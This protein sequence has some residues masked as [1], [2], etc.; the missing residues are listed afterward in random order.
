MSRVDPK[1]RNQLAFGV[2]IGCGV[3]AL[4]WR[5]KH[6][7]D[8]PSWWKKTTAG[9]EDATE[10]RAAS[11]AAGGGGGAG[12]GAGAPSSSAAPMPHLDR[13][14]ADEMR[15]AIR[16]LLAEAGVGAGW[17]T[18][19]APDAAAAAAAAAGTFPEMPSSELRDD[20]GISESGKYI[21]S[22]VR[23]DL[24][25]LARQC[26]ETATKKDPKLA[27]TIILHFRIVGDRRIGG[28]VDTASAD[29]KSDLKDPEF[30]K[31]MIESMMSVSF[32]A[33]PGKSGQVT[34][35]YPIRFSPEEEEDGGS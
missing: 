32:D 16:A 10:P 29:E 27:G 24:F 4:A 22:R 7:G 19:D 28:V 9:D 5:V 12:A 3:L 1:T 17:A 26:Y 6:P 23:E 13:K 30:T 14:R 8:T 31:C 11:A 20:A 25:P 21:Q 35:T 18:T 2:A 15:E 33:P 34:V